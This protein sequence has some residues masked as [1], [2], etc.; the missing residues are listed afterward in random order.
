VHGKIKKIKA[1]Q[2]TMKEDAEFKLFC[3]E[4]TDK[5]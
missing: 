2:T 3:N 1:A 4:W 5:I